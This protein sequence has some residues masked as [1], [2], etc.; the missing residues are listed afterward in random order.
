MSGYRNF[1]RAF[2]ADEGGVTAVEYGLI[3]AG[4]SIVVTTAVATVGESVRT[5]LFE[6]I[7]AALS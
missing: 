3:L 5:A 6:T 2:R 7:A 4:L 1:L